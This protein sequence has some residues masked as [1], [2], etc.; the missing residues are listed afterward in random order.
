[1][2]EGR[3]KHPVIGVALGLL[4]VLAGAVVLPIAAQDDAG[5]QIASAAVS[6]CAAS[7]GVNNTAPI[8]IDAL[9]GG[10][11]VT[12]GVPGLHLFEGGGSWQGSF[13]TQEVLTQTDVGPS[14]RIATIREQSGS[15]TVM[16]V[17]SGTGD[18]QAFTLTD[19]RPTS[20]FWANAT[21]LY[22][23]DIRVR[24]IVT[25]SLDDGTVAP[26][27]SGLPEFSRP[28]ASDPAGELYVEVFDG[29]TFASSI[30][31]YLPDGSLA[32]EFPV[33]G[34]ALGYADAASGQLI[35]VGLQITTY[36]PDGSVV[37]TTPSG[38]T[39]A[40][41]PPTAAVTTD[42]ALWIAD[43]EL[44]YRSPGIGQ[45][46]APFAIPRPAIGVDAPG[47]AVGAGTFGTTSIGSRIDDQNGRIVGLTGT[48]EQFVHASGLSAAVIRG[49]GS[50][51]G[52]IIWLVEADDGSRSLATSG[53]SFESAPIGS[54]AIVDSVGGD[55]PGIWTV[56]LAGRLWR[57]TPGGATLVGSNQGIVAGFV[58]VDQAYRVYA[59][60]RVTVQP[61]I[62]LD[63]G[64]ETTVVE[65]A[66]YPT[67]PVVRDLTIQFDAIWVADASG[68]VHAFAKQSG[69]PFGAIT[70]IGG[71][72][73]GPLVDPVAA[74]ASTDGVVVVDRG[75]LAIAT[76]VCDGP[77]VD[78]TPTPPVVGPQFTG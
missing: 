67:P 22:L 61:I 21:T 7:R 46:A 5:D 56:D 2:I 51:D 53:G 6:T 18:V 47:H 77:L 32:V 76:I 62:G 49:V 28:V 16:V 12:T 26:F 72:G 78:Q 45:T 27:I 64:T 11:F 4:A 30:R 42:G 68:A 36:A 71:L 38:L 23:N 34:E 66:D 65:P 9:P 75:T 70:D 55:L 35:A 52:G 50:A 69:A 33:D 25:L 24:R 74:M 14:G 39:Q 15:T 31:R 73:G 3:R 43:P 19:V 54:V 37:S 60:G 58:D 13:L 40:V 1:M 41:T 10:G 63:G 17:D 57:T 20:V 29:A 44:V 8:D 48:I 59:D